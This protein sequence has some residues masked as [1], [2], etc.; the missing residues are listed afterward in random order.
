MPHI[1]YCGIPSL[2]A[3]LAV[4]DIAPREGIPKA[5]KQRLEAVG[6]FTFLFIK[7]NGSIHVKSG[8]H[9]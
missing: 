8:S 1:L 3:R 2:M 5:E 6:F 7:Y 4:G 9:A